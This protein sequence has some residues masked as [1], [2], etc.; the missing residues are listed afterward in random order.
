[1]QVAVTPVVRQNCQHFQL[2]QHFEN[3]FDPV[4]NAV[5]VRILHGCKQFEIVF[6]LR[7]L[8]LTGFGQSHFVRMSNVKQKLS[9]FA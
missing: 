3:L 8:G 5:F 4:L 9:H 2:R 7:H 6:A 1:V